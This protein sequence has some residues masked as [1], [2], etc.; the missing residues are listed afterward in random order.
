[1]LQKLFRVRPNDRIGLDLYAKTVEQARDPAF[2]TDLGVA[3]E[4]DARFELYTLHI[5]LLI[6][7]LRDEGEAGAEIAQDLFDV[8]VS[9]LDN[10][11]RELGVHDVTVGKKM[12]KLGE[13][14]Y[15]RMTAYEGPV[16]AADK[17]A[18]AEALSRNVYSGAAGETG[19]RLADYALRARVGLAGQSLKQVL[20]RPAWAE[21]AA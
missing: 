6:L 4:I 19:E 17:A 5:L 18:L 11:L 7:R 20:A 1:M 12:R 13:A 8:Y 16:R 21:V 9:A 15:G 10:A 3:D 2:F 14:L